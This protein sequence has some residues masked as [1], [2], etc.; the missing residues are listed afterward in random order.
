MSTAGARVVLQRLLDSL[1][2]IPAIYVVLALALSVGLV[3]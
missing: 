1:W 3:R 2:F